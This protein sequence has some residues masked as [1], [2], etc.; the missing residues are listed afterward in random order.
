VK[1]GKEVAYDCTHTRVCVRGSLSLVST[2]EKILV[3]TRG[4]G[5]ENREYGRRDPLR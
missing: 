4:S 1:H 5:V 2:T 3:K